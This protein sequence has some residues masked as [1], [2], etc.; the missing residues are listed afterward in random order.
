MQAS[1]VFRVWIICIVSTSL[2]AAPL[3]RRA[4]GLRVPTLLDLSQLFSNVRPEAIELNKSKPIAGQKL[5]DTEP[6][7]NEPLGDLGRSSFTPTKHSPLPASQST[8]F[9]PSERTSP[10]ESEEMRTRNFKPSRSQKATNEIPKSSR[11]DQSPHELKHGVETKRPLKK[12][13]TNLKRRI[14]RFFEKVRIT[15]KRAFRRGH[16][17]GKSKEQAR[18]DEHGAIEFEPS[19][20]PIQTLELAQP[21]EKGALSVHNTGESEV[22]PSLGSRIFSV[23]W[24][25]ASFVLEK[26]KSYVPPRFVPSFFQESVPPTVCKSCG[27]LASEGPPPKSFEEAGLQQA[28][29]EESIKMSTPAFHDAPL[30]IVKQ[31]IEKY[32]RG[33]IEK[34]TTK[35]LTPEKTKILLYKARNKAK[36]RWVRWTLKIT[37]PRVFHWFLKRK[38]APAATKGAAKWVTAKILKLLPDLGPRLNSLH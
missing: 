35:E 22:S 13:F 27:K 25:M 34:L 10:L 28:S 29:V 37:P 30:D 21:H 2:K 12:L 32:L 4:V 20:P 3:T 26:A 1:L 24:S 9:Q 16:T 23:P 6:L 7:A 38:I 19:V 31:E 18:H 33:F 15:F 14:D 8:I 17:S 5:G 11:P 36:S